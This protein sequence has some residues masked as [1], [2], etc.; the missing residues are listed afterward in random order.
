MSLLSEQWKFLQDVCKLIN[1]IAIKGYIAS[2]G[3]LWRSP[4][5]QKI[6]LETGRSKTSTSYHLDRLAIDLN[7]F[8]KEGKLII[9]KEDLQEI[10]DYWESLDSKNKWGGNFKTFLDIPH[11]EKRGR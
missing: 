5:T 8:N 7:I 1:F 11:F 4:E 10:G 9:R 3:E 2:G 6:Y